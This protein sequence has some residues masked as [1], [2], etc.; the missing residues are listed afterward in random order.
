MSKDFSFAIGLTFI[1]IVAVVFQMTY[2]VLSPFIGWPLIVMFSGGAWYFFRNAFRQKSEQSHLN[3]ET[4]KSN[5]KNTIEYRRKQASTSLSRWMKLEKEL[6]EIAKQIPE[7][8]SV[9]KKQNVKDAIYKLQAEGNKLALV[10]NRQ[11]FDEYIEAVLFHYTNQ[12]QS[13]FD[14]Y[15]HITGSRTSNRIHRNIRAAIRGIKK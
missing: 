11:E 1:A 7:G 15:E 3:S 4:G 13:H 12:L 14:P 9:L 8:E 2:P 10:I 5:K 6:W